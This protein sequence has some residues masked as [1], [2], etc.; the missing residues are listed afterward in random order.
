[1]AQDKPN[2][3]PCRVSTTENGETGKLIRRCA[4]PRDIFSYNRVSGGHWSNKTKSWKQTQEWQLWLRSS[5]GLD[6]PEPQKE[7]RRRLVITR[8]VGPRMKEM[9]VANFPSGMKSVEDAIVNLGWLI[10]DSRKYVDTEMRQIRLNEAEEWVKQKAGAKIVVEVYE[11]DSP[12]CDR[13]GDRA[14]P[15]RRKR[16]GSADRGSLQP[17]DGLSTAAAGAVRAG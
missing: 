3:K 7:F 2:P 14:E 8:V 12:I 17:D 1:M 6:I 15:V 13:A 11:L 10:D 5:E 4:L 16:R 9:E